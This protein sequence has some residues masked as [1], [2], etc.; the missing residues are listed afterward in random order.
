MIKNYE[1][2]YQ[3]LL[4][5]TYLSFFSTTQFKNLRKTKK[6]ICES[7]I[8]CI[9]LVCF[10]PYSHINSGGLYCIM[11]KMFYQ[12]HIFCRFSFVPE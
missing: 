4:G 9:I 3:T 5:K 11:Y 12:L 1:L 6:C 7:S 8:N 10:L 2:L